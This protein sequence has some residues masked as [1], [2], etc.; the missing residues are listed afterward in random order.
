MILTLALQRISQNATPQQGCSIETQ[1]DA[2]V[3]E[4]CIVVLASK[5]TLKLHQ[6]LSWF[7]EPDIIFHRTHAIHLRIF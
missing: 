4:S 2:I 1:P 7:P 5:Q 6:D 3:K